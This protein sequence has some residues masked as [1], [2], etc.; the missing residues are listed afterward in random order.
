MGHDGGVRRIAALSL[1]PALVVAACGGGVGIQRTP[2]PVPSVATTAAPAR[3]A[4]LEQANAICGAAD[5]EVRKRLAAL[6]DQTVEALTDFVGAVFV[7]VWRQALAALRALTPPAG[8]EALLE[9]LWADLEAHL[10]EIEAAPRAFVDRESSLMAELGDR[11][12]AYG[13]TSCG[14]SR[15]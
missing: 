3:Q 2:L 14:T 8:D 1:A 13:L 10:D 12:D 6:A 11:F 9:E 4:Y 7:P 5:R 15:S